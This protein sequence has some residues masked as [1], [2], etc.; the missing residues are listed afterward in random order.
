MNS[1]FF[2]R[3]NLLQTGMAASLGALGLPGLAQSYPTKPI[4]I[5]N[6]TPGG[7]ADVFSRVYG[8]MVTEVLGQP[9]VVDPK[10][11]AGGVVALTALAAAAPD[12]YTLGFANSSALWQNRV[13]YKKL[14]YDPDR[15]FTPVSL[16]SGGPLVMAVSADVPADNVQAFIAWC[17]AN[18]SRASLAT[19]GPGS[20][21]HMAAEAIN[22]SAGMSI[23]IVHYKTPSAMWTDVASGVTKVGFAGYQSFEPLHQKGMLRPIGVLGGKFRSPRLPEIATLAQQGMT[24]PLFSLDTALVLLAPGG[25]PEPILQALADVA[26]KGGETPRGRRLREQLSIPMEA[27]P[28][29]LDE[30]RRRSRAEAPVWIDRARKLGI[31]L[32]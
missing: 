3:R 2:N 7:L 6:G 13:L 24:D 22:Q 16:W 10:P 31:T 19:Y 14:P 20:V 5:I 8:E 15:D 30:T 9:I 26:L 25:T 11:G 12:G 27:R 23:P 4:K 1:K 18:P 17:K 32:D 21:A 29:G 28:T